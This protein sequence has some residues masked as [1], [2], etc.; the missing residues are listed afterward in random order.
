M[1]DK[2]EILSIFKKYQQV[3]HDIDNIPDQAIVE[4]E[5]DSVIDEIINYMN[6]DKNE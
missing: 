3:V 5:Y 2:E 6:I 4:Y 1:N